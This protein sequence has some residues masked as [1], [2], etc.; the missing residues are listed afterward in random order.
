MQRVLSAA[1][2]LVDRAP[3]HCFVPPLLREL[4]W[5]PVRQRIHYKILLLT[6]KIVRGN[7]P[8][9]LQE[10]ILVK[11]PGA[12]RLRSS[13]NG[14]L[15][16]HP[17]RWTRTTLGDRSFQVAAPKLWNAPPHEICSISDVNTFN[18]HLKTHLFSD[19]FLEFYLFSFLKYVQ[20][21]L[22][23]I[24]YCIFV[25][26]LHVKRIWSFLWKRRSISF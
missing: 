16:K 23:Y 18:R 12:Y 7:S 22:F 13:C 8:L 19:A 9:Y 21:I 6:F 4:H 26:S 15:L 1:A 24:V 5:L 17:S 3:R 25:I 10:L 20:Y 2:R 14:L 11:K